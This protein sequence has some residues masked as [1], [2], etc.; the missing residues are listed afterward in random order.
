MIRTSSPPVALLTATLVLCIWVGGLASGSAHAQ[1]VENNS[2]SAVRETLLPSEFARF[3]PRTALDMASQIPGFPL[4]EGGDERGFGQADTNV[5]INN[6]RI[7]GK[8]NG[9]VAALSRIPA[10][11]VVRLEI[12]DGA[13]L[14]IVG[15]SGQVLNVVTA[16]GGGLSGRYR[17]SPEIRTDEVP[18][19]WGDGEIAVSGGGDRTE[20][21]LSLGN[22]QRHRGSDGPEFVTDGQGM[23]LDERFERVGERSDQPGIS[24]LFTR[25]QNSGS[26][27]NLTGEINWLL[28]RSE[29]RSERNPINDVARVRELRETEDEFNFEIGADYEFKFGPGRLKLIGLHRFEDSPTDAMVDTQF[30]DGRPLTG[31]FFRRNAEEAESVLRAEYNF[32]ALA[33][34]WQWS[35]EGAQNFL[36]I[37]AELSVRDVA[38]ILVDVD[39]PGAS[40]RVEEDRAEMTLSYGRPLGNRLQLQTSL[41]AEYSKIRQTGAFSQT[42][43]FVRPKGFVSLNWEAS[44]ATNLSLQM[45]R[46]VAQLEFS[47]VIATVNVNQ[48]RVNV[49]NAELVPPQSWLTELQ[50]QQSLGSYGSLT[51]SGFYE[52]I[53]DIVDLIPVDNGAAG[54]GQAPGNIDSANRRGGALNATLLFDP[55]GWRGARLDIAAN[56]TDSEVRDP[57]IGNNRRI[58][59]EDFITYEVRFRQDFPGTTWAAGIEAFYGENAPQV[60]LDEVSLFRQS[61]A[62][63]RAFIENKNVF[64]ATLRATLGNLNDRSNDFSRTL[65][66]DR[67]VNDIATREERFL[68]FGLLFQLEIEGSF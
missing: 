23:L 56:Y 34:D 12:L 37:E 10:S 29:E 49:T 14:D 52:A 26:I 36:D 62:F 25:E 59:D 51:L 47:D 32:S 21:S 13:S 17:Y 7:S 11:D 15:L 3:A 63:T 39:F 28:F 18:F 16:T 9:P 67:S 55:L 24:G 66:N 60:R 6:R 30:A 43:D 19:R 5:L 48:N 57:L 4:E 54:I 2:N 64:G 35:L 45:E 41:G 58:S 50:L 61:V 33:G 1:V 8:S 53:S 42:R 27:L 68:D 46:V 38:G 40:D 31:S 65:F 44:S 20:W 22:E